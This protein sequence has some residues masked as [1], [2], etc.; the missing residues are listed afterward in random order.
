MVQLLSAGAFVHV[1]V[2]GSYGNEYEGYCLQGRGA[3]WFGKYSSLVSEE[4][5]EFV[6]GIDGMHTATKFGWMV[7]PKLSYMSTEVYDIR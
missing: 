1:K 7:S 2:C 6:F 3:V 5:A 4:Y